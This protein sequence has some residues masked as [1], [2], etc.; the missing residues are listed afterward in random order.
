MR[1]KYFNDVGGIILTREMEKVCI[2]EINYSRV[3]DPEKPRKSSAILATNTL[4]SKVK[5]LKFQY[6][7][8]CSLDNL[9]RNSAS[10]ILLRRI[11]DEQR[12]E[13]QSVKD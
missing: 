9:A 12:F 1:P 2:Y 11:E 13:N 8:H 5:R 7:S 10:L 4:I 3:R 6:H